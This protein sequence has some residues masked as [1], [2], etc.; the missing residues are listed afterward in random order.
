MFFV[1]HPT[2]TESVQTSRTALSVMSAPL[3]SMIM[4]NETGREGK[5]TFVCYS[6]AEKT[7]NGCLLCYPSLLIN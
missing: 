5:V 3:C 6:S 4:I 2:W 7:E 1:V